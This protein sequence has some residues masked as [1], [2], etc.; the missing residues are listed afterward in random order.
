MTYDEYKL[1]T[2]PS[3]EDFDQMTEVEQ[4]EQLIYEQRQKNE[5]NKPIIKE[6]IGYCEVNEHLSWLHKKLIQIKL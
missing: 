2:P 3:A 5:F 4:L 6:L 1:Q